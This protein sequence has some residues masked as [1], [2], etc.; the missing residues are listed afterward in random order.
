M[1]DSAQQ[2]VGSVPPLVSP[3]RVVIVHGQ[4]AFAEALQERLS[5]EPD[6]DVVGTAADGR[7]AL[8]A[9]TNLNPDLVLLD[10]HLGS[11][12]GLAVGVQLRDIAP[13]AVFV[14]VTGVDDPRA[15]VRAVRMGVRAWVSMDM[16]VDFLLAAVRAAPQGHSLFPPALLGGMLPLLARPEA[17]NRYD[18]LL[19]GLTDRERQILVCMI[20]GLDRRAIARRLQLS[21]NTVRTHV[22]RVL[23]K[24]QVHSSLEAVALALTAGVRGDERDESAESE[25]VRGPRD[26]FSAAGRSTMW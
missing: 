24:L 7:S 22:Q 5:A 9:V 4:P 20:D 11:E 3:L 14:A 2:A 6:I 23:A 1:T 18:D 25:P 10:L 26:Q 17:R 8:T 16:G 15:A 19:A 12:D 13:R 21:S